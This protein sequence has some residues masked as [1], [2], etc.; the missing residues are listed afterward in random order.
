MALAGPAAE[1]V[2]IWMIFL[3]AGVVCPAMAVVALI[4]ARMPEDE[5]AH[6]LDRGR[7]AVRSQKARDA[8]LHE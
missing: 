4:A 7:A 5:L 2:P 1:V 3:V 6:P 8:S